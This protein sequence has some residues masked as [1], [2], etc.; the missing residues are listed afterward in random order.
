MEVILVV[1]VLY[2]C[3][4]KE[5]YLV[6]KDKY[7]VIKDNHQNNDSWELKHKL[8]E[9]I[10]DY[11]IYNFFLNICVVCINEWIIKGFKL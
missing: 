9:L 7:L 3:N 8:L 10:Y 11:Y 1:L 5:K 4:V 6:I 2:Y